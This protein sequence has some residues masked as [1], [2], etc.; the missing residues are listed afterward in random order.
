M[1]KNAYL[2]AKIGFDPAENE[3][4]KECCVV[5]P[6]RAHTP[7]LQIELR[8]QAPRQEA[9]RIEPYAR[10]FYPYSISR[11]D[12]TCQTGLA[13]GRGAWRSV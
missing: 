3:P 10:L 5:A 12:V 7:A 9:A 11:K 4:R 6:R 2:D 1:L 8:V 13:L